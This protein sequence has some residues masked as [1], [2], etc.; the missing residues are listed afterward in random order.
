MPMD[1]LPI[2]VSFVFGVCRQFP[3]TAGLFSNRCIF[4]PQAIQNPIG[5]RIFFKQ[6]QTGSIWNA[7]SRFHDPRPMLPLL[8]GAY[9]G[10]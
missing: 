3:K 8:S 6:L 10:H 5:V 4:T 1:F 2:P 7:C 9:P